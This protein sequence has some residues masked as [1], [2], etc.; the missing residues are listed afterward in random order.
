[1]EALASRFA[2]LTPNGQKLLFSATDREVVIGA[3][4]LT[5][6]GESHSVAKKSYDRL[7]CQMRIYNCQTRTIFS[8]DKMSDDW[9]TIL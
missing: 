2:I 9:R 8:S 3:D 4:Q 1:M 6:S 5:V 7:T